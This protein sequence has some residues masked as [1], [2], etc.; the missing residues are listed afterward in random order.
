MSDSAIEAK[1]KEIIIEQLDANAEDIRP[2]ASFIDDLQAD[3]LA[4]VEL[5][6]ALEE[7][8]DIK[9]PDD[10]VDRIKTVGDAVKYIEDRKG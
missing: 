4:V 7:N 10:E 5:V 2:E 6:L 8:F 9:I 1:V 3:S